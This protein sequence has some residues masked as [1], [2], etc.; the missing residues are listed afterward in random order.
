MGALTFQDLSLDTKFSPSKCFDTVPLI[1][2]FLLQ[3]GAGIDAR[4]EKINF[5]TLDCPIDPIFCSLVHLSF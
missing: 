3:G 1:G 5:S 4:Y 2:K